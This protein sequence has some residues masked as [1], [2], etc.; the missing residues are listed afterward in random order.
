LSD[1]PHENEEGMD[2]THRLTL[3]RHGLSVANRDGIVQGQ[4]DFPLAE[5]GIQQAKQLAGFWKARDVHYRSIISSPL[6]RAKQ[7]AEIIAEALGD[8][9]QYNDIWMERHQGDAQGMPYENAKKW[10]VNETQPSIHDPIYNTGESEWELYCRGGD[11]L[12]QLLRLDPA[13]YLIVSHGAILG[14]A[15]RSALGIPPRDSFNAARLSFDNTGYAVLNYE[16]E[17]PRWDLHTL[18]QTCHL[19]CGKPEIFGSTE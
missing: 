3:L 19:T 16:S 8:D 7:T 13:E 4:R 18:N 15:L 10:Y 5:E 2:M 14:A 6:V 12:L 17:L 11:G 1:P 9:I